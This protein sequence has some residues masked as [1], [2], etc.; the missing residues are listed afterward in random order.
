MTI[1]RT[2]RSIVFLLLLPL[3]ALSSSLAAQAP[4]AGGRSTG[5]EYERRVRQQKLNGQYIP[6][7]IYD[8]MD[9]LDRL[10]DADSR[11]KFASA[12]ED[13]VVERL[14]FSLGR[15]M[16]VNWGLYEG[17]RIAAYLRELGVDEPD[18]QIEFLMRAYHRHVREV[19]LDVRQLATTYKRER[20]L[21]DSLRRVEF[22]GESSG[23]ETLS[24]VPADSLGQQSD[25]SDASSEV[26][27]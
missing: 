2:L 13:L 6:S 7:D 24:A 22:L 16:A 4:G 5:E 27:D 23:V 15:W 10:V 3:L 26:P 25:T 21:R 14:F 19:D 20:R 8:A 9:A 18:G 17:S 1:S 11:E 12:P